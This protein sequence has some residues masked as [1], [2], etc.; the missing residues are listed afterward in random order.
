MMKK[1]IEL[2]A[3]IKGTLSCDYFKFADVSEKKG[4]RASDDI[5]SDPTR[6]IKEVGFD[7][8]FVGASPFKYLKTNAYIWEYSLL[9]LCMEL[10]P[11]SIK[12]EKKYGHL[13]KKSEHIIRPERYIGHG[14]GGYEKWNDLYKW[15]VS[16]KDVTED[17]KKLAR[18]SKPFCDLLLSRDV[19]IRD[20]GKT[21]KESDKYL[22][23]RK[24]AASAFWNFLVEK[25]SK[26]FFEM[27]CYDLALC[28]LLKRG[29]EDIFSKHVIA[30]SL[31]YCLYG[32]LRDKKDEK[33][34]NSELVKQLIVRLHEIWPKKTDVQH[35]VIVYLKESKQTHLPSLSKYYD[36]WQQKN[37][38]GSIQR[39][40]IFRRIN[41]WLDFLTQTYT[42]KCENIKDVKRKIIPRYV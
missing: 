3:K 22:K 7:E 23:L 12:V 36:S 2:S 27:N 31:L 21:K 4:S 28:A 39:I 16:K 26:F 35:N 13:L 15:N 38:Y 30:V 25:K 5:W 34:L 37:D 33:E 32:R 40:N 10:F 1:H 6:L 14:P 17:V 20:Y 29:G 42:I 18:A 11:Q 41:I 24:Q 9:H 19:G 8:D